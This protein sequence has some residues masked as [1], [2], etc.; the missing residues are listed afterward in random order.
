MG[1]QIKT[2]LCLFIELLTESSLNN[3]RREQSA[4]FLFSSPHIEQVPI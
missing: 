2:K 3:K 4:A 1:K